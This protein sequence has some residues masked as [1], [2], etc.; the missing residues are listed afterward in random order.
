MTQQSL[1]SH[2][3]R[4]RFYPLACPRLLTRLKCPPTFLSNVMLTVSISPRASFTPTTAPFPPM[5]PPYAKHLYAVSVTPIRFVLTP[6]TS[7]S[8]MRPFSLISTSTRTYATVLNQRP[9][10]LGKPILGLDHFLQ[11]QRV[12]ALWRE[13]VR[14]IYKIPALSTRVEMRDFAREEFERNRHVTEL[15]QIRYLI[16]TG[17]T[18]FNSMRRY[19]DEQARG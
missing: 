9:S 1:L 15:G 18:Q 14:A 12:I 11:R 2:K 10:R 17:K 8:S 13:I 4:F 7:P 6:L 19:I 5:T 16:S 3:S